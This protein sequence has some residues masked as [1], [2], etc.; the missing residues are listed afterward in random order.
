MLLLFYLKERG[1]RDML[2]SKAIYQG[3]WALCFMLVS[4]LSIAK[5]QETQKTEH[6][7]HQYYE[8]IE[9]EDIDN[10][11]RLLSA[12][13]VHEIN[14]GETERGK[15]KFRNFMEDQFSHG[16]FDIKDL[17]ILT[18][19]D[20][21]YATTRFICSGEYYKTLAGYPSAKGQKWEIPVVSFFKIEQG[22][23]S[24]VAVYFND[25][26]FRKQLS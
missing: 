22:K 17:I 12:D 15:Q 26:A 8:Y 10:F 16:K 2:F 5:T 11:I 19:P 3:F 1:Y 6:L 7:I 13:V 24:H 20:G 23:I 4:G 25:T 14:Q 18:S 21:K 9:K